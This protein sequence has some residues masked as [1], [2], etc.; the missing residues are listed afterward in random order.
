MQKVGT[1]LSKKQRRQNSSQ[2]RATVIALSDETAIYGKVTGKHGDRWFSVTIYDEKNNRH[3]PEVKAH[4]ISKKNTARVEIS[5]I[6]NLALSEDDDPD[7]PNPQRNWGSKKWEIITPLDDGAVKQLKKDGRISDI[8]LMRDAM[9]AKTI[10]EMD[11]LVSKGI[12]TDRYDLGIEFE[13]DEPEVTEDTNTKKKDK[14]S[15]KGEAR[16]HRVID[17]D[18]EVDVDAI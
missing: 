6:V 14:V 13:R 11:T 12:S 1:Q 2:K 17:D 8:L 3:I 10:R 5:S 9:D 16:T 18:G 4:I 15:K 7:D